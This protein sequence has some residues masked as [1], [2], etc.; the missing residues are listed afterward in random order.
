MQKIIR[1]ALLFVVLAVGFVSTAPTQEIGAQ[2]PGPPLP[3]PTIIPGCKQILECI[4]EM[5]FDF[6]TCRCVPRP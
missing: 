5:V 4:P 1:I 6:K 3:Q 2:T